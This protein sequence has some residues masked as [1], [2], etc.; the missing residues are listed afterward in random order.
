LA[1]LLD[2]WIEER[3]ELPGPDLLEFKEDADPEASA[4]SLRQ[5]W[6]LG[7]KPI[8]NMIHLLEAKGIRVF[9]LVEN[10]RAVD[11]FS[12]WRRNTPYV[13]LNTTKT[14]ERSRFDAAHELGHLVLHKHGVA[15]GRAL[16]MQAN[17]FAAAF[18]MPEADVRAKLPRVH[19][20]NQIVEA[21]KIWR[22]SVSALNYRLHKLEIISDWQYRTFCIQIVER[23]KQ[24]EPY[25]LGR[26][27]S[28]VLDKV[29]KALTTERIN[30]YDIASCLSL[31]VF[32][33]E[34]LVFQLTNMQC[35]DGKGTNS[36]RSKASLKLISNGE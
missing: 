1:F 28:Q 29:F 10:S 24:A 25:G 33:I 8:R 9:S 30:K 21:K 32:E 5:K 11:A 23:F 20:L 27:L 36:G 15:Q 35:I 31:P 18:L 2:D 34:N 19:S 14:A 3:F 13:F 17:Q 4:R 12:V 22:V 16:E 6:G 26:E 7:E